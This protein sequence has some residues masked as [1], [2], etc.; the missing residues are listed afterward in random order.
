MIGMG[1][2]EKTSRVCVLDKGGYVVKEERGYDPESAATDVR[3]DEAL[4]HCDRSGNASP[5]VSRLL[6]RCRRGWHAR[7]GA[8][9]ADQRGA[10][11]IRGM[12]S[13]P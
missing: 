6:R 8:V 13:P 2:D 3:S 9:T 11:R 5:W 12:D 10:W 4:P 7:P 1:L